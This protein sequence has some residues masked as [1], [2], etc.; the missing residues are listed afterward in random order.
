MTQ[1]VRRSVKL[2]G[3]RRF[4]IVLACIFG[5]SAIAVGAA[6]DSR[7]GYERGTAWAKT[8]AGALPDSLDELAAFP[9]GYRFAIIREM[10]PEVIVQLWKQQYAEALRL[11]PEWSPQQ[12]QFVESLAARMTPEDIGIKTLNTCGLVEAFFPKY[13]DRQIFLSR[14]LGILG[15]PRLTVA[16]AA[17]TARE[18]VTELLTAH[19]SFDWC[20]CVTGCSGFCSG[21]QKCNAGNCVPLLSCACAGQNYDCDG[22]C[23][24]AQPAIPAK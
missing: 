4:M 15:H 2:A 12:R 18:K 6:T 11:H 20:S 23:E 3:S 21:G 7:N 22:K 9:E 10:R 1:L 14:N 8:H 17:A 5:L 19:A 13:Q 24:A 16:A